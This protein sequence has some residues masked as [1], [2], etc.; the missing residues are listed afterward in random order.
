MPPPIFAAVSGRLALVSAGCLL[1]AACSTGAVPRSPAGDLSVALP[2]PTS[3]LRLARGGGAVRAYDGRT[4]A[5][6][7]WT[8]EPLPAIS[9][10]VGADADQRRVIAVDTKRGLL[11]LDL[12]TRRA[13]PLGAG[14]V[15]AVALGPDGTV[16]SID[17]ALVVTA[18]TRRS[19]T[20]TPGLLTSLP[21]AVFGALSGR[22]LAFDRSGT[23]LHAVGGSLPAA[24]APIVNGAIATT[25]YAELFAVA[26]D[27]GVVLYEPD[28]TRP[29]RFVEVEGRARAVAFSP[30]GHRFYVGTESEGVREFDRFG[31]ADE[32]GRIELPGPVEA[33]RMDREGR[34]LLAKPAGR[35]SVWVI[36]LEARKAVA[37]IATSWAA[38]LPVV[39]APGLVAVR[40]QTDV[41]LVNVGGP[42]PVEAARVPG[43]AADAWLATA[44]SPVRKA[45]PAADST[46]AVPQPTPEDS[47]EAKIDSV[48]AEEPS[49]DPPATEATPEVVVAE[50]RPTG[51]VY[52]QVSSSR[53]PAWVNN[54][55]EQLKRQGL[56][57]SVLSPAM[58]DEPYRVVLGPYPT[59]AAA[60]EA[61]RQVGMPSFVIMVAPP[62]G[63]R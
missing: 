9:V 17:T 41:V 23:M 44:W 16:W 51:L 24:D 47:I 27:S 33:L 1:V 36:D 6:L 37:A 22:L 32:R 39:S 12:G 54:L 57:A 55:A 25:M 15:A 21:R 60:E 4:L 10:V 18:I 43:G 31:D 28:R 61:G 8:S 34:W 49:A 19:T 3:L 2:A 7:D 35:D 40:W 42:K 46:P 38:D 48:L 62:A 53:N 26:A 20:R 5:A 14:G 11:S 30:S 13:R 29:P 56:K 59:R 50:E 52:L 63:Q 45:V 58:P